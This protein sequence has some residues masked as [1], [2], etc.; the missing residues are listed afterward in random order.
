MVNIEIMSNNILLSTNCQ[1][2][3]R[4]LYNRMLSAHFSSREPER[5]RKSPK[6]PDEASSLVI[7]LLSMYGT[8]G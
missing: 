3:N 2:L 1:D 8:I 5:A 6:G 4:L 7:V